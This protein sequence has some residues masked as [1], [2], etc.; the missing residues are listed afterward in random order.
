MRLFLHV[1]G[2][3]FGVFLDS[4]TF[5]RFCLRL[6]LLSPPKISFCATLRED[7]CLKKI[8]FKTF[9]SIFCGRQA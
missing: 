7:C 1:V 8:A 6:P 5:I 3:I 4:L 9:E 2:A